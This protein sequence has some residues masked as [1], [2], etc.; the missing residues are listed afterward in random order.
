MKNLVNLFTG[1]SAVALCFSI[2]DR[3][4]AQAVA[5]DTES[6]SPDAVDERDGIQDI[7]VTAQKRE[8]ALNDVPLSITAASGEQLA[9]VGV[10]D[11]SALAKL[12]PGFSYTESAY[13]TPVFTLRGIGFYDTS[14]GAK[15]T[16]SVYIDQ[17][18]LPFSIMTRGSTL[19]L[20][21]VEVLKGPQGTLFGS[22]ATGGAINYVAARPTTTLEAGFDAGL[23][24]FGKVDL[25]GYVSGPLSDKAAARIAVRTEQGGAW[26][27]S[28]TRD[29]KLGG[30]NFTTGRFL[31]DLEPTDTLS[32]Q[33][34][35][36]G[37]IDK[38]DGQAAQLIGVVPLG[39]P[40]RLGTLATYPIAPANNR[41][42]DWSVGQE[43]KRDNW[44]YQASLRSDLELGDSN[45]ITALTAYSRYDH[46][47]AIDPDGVALR[48]YFYNTLGKITAFSQE[49]RLEGSSGDL[50]YIL[51]GNYSRE[52]V[53]QRDNAGPYPDATSAYQLVDGGLSQIPF[54][55]YSQYSDQKFVNKA[56]FANLDYQIGDS[57]T[58]HGGIRYTDTRI[59]YAGC[60][61]DR[62]FALGQGFQNLLNSI[63]D[64]AGLGP[65]TIPDGACVTLNSATL[66]AGEVTGSLSEDNI[67]WRAG[68][69][70]KPN[71]DL[72]FYASASKGY[73]SGSYP[74]LS[75]SD[76]NQLNPVTQE[77][78]VAYE[79][80]T[81]ATLGRRA[82]LNAALF[83]YD[84]SDK[85]LKGR[86]VATPDVFGPLETLV[87]V[88]Q[89]S[90]TGGEIQ[91]DLA[92]VRGLAI[93]LAGTYIETK[94][95]GSFFNYDS[96]GNVTDFGGSAFPYTPKFQGVADIQYEWDASSDISPF[97]GANMS[98]QSSTKAALGDASITPSPALTALGGLNIDDYALVDLRAGASLDGEKYRLAFY[99]RNL[100]DTY[101]WSNATRVTDTTVR[102]AGRPRTYGVSLSARF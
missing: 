102:F 66:T 47:T 53:F 62:G 80:G 73:K 97:V 90:V 30:S 8:Q 4:E 83:Y 43:P 82:Q 28:Y 56:V 84:Y 86:V 70:Y 44:A 61:E 12:V 65:I 32:F 2:S 16:V 20:E 75:A 51:G 94:I 67:S 52:K 60:T 55:I 89:S 98:Y 72:L 24:S 77:S 19:D 78:V 100:F 93:S 87:N 68:V 49:L 31:L 46:D 21:R 1:A 59:Q 17:V 23:D 88:P 39:N 40:D 41:D 91:L 13:A 34:N 69:D 79:I 5:P 37:F 71:S 74:I 35:L 26:Q 63:R 7:V 33:L 36:N 22:N 10:T 101:Y 99:V 85:Q 42:A 14:L 50:T 45:R 95:R 6:V 38:S 15:P 54:F 18:P 11:V 48:N 57:I 27:R 3:A 64:G 29:A 25:G 58:L 92:P 76:A 81:K 9:N 96:Y